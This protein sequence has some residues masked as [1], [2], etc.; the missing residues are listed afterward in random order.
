LPGWA[1][2]DSLFVLW[3]SLFLQQTAQ[4][5][6]AEIAYKTPAEVD[7]ILGK[8]REVIPTS[9]PPED[10]PGEY[11]GYGVK[12]LGGS[13]IISVVFYR[14]RAVKV[15][16][17]SIDPPAST[18]EGALRLVG[19]SERS[20][21]E[22]P[23]AGNPNPERA[24]KWTGTVDGIDLTNIHAFNNG[25]SKW[26]SVSVSFSRSSMPTSSPGSQ[27]SEP[28]ALAEPRLVV[29]FKNGKSKPIANYTEE[30]DSFVLIGLTGG[31]GR[32]PRSM[33]DKIERLDGSVPK[34]QFRTWTDDSGKFEI[35]AELVGV[36]D[37]IVQLKKSDG[38]VKAVPLDKLSGNDR[39]FIEEQ[40]GAALDLSS[41]ESDPR[42]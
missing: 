29:H 24:K 30:D 27:S 40:R 39:R 12:R 23:D 21:I 28:V 41:E 33:I 15:S 25:P 26:W 37:G 18:S 13:F 42:P 10:V 36:E 31:R 35:E 3:W 38:K 22:I 19:L 17:D 2:L 7:R 4:R 1:R 9:S 34:S 5:R 6:A 8:P 11:H 14:G 16:I 20:L 32:Y